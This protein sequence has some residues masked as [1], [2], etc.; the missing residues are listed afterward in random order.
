M[1]MAVALI[2]GTTAFAN[3]ESTSTIDI[4]EVSIVQTNDDGYASVKLEELNEKVQ[5][6]IQTYVETYEVAELTYH[7]ERKLTKVTLVDRTDHSE[8]VVV[9]DDEGK[10]T[11]DAA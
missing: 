10:E 4:N 7:A 1:M 2:V 6:T 8:K 5:A 3:V 9:L 11:E